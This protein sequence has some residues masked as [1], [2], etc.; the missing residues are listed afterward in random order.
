MEIEE[1]FRDF[2]KRG[3]IAIILINQNVSSLMYTIINWEI[4]LAV[5][6]SADFFEINF[7][8]ILFQVYHL[9]VKQIGSISDPTF[10][11]A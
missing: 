5:F 8:E 3:D 7:F 11:Q 4:F 2:V 10:C 9:S 6:S 1:K